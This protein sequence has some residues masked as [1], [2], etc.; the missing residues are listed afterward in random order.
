MLLTD[1]TADELLSNAKRLGVDYL[2]SALE[3]PCSFP[4]SGK[5]HGNNKRLMISLLP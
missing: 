2:G 1:I 4:K 3:F 5:I